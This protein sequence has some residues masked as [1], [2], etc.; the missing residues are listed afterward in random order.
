MTS[1]KSAL[2]LLHGF[3]MS[4]RAW[5]DVVPLLSGHHDVFTPTTAGHRGG[6]PVHRSPVTVSDLVD[7]TERYLDDHGLMRPHVA[8]LSLGGWMA[9]ELARRGRAKTVCALAPGGFWTPG[10]AAQAQGRRKIHQFLAMARLAARARPVT[11]LA[12]RVPG[13]RQFGLRDAAC[14]A[15]RITAAQALV[16]ID[17]MV[18]C[19]ID[20]DDITGSPEH[21]APF[22]PLP[23]PVT[24]A[25]A[26]K[27]A[28]IRQPLCGNTARERLP[29][30]TFTTLP[31]V[32][33]AIMMDDPALVARTI[34]AVTAQG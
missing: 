17:D 3:R 32:G 31:G 15:G 30:A 22:D 8:G 13:V 12:L 26:G 27:D 10:D 5:D 34:L 24:I 9:I 7:Q 21:V 25:W 28:L 2:V 23:C 14:H 16:A 1:E 29:H 20:V 6:P 18:G 4:G 33:H 11:A 19:T